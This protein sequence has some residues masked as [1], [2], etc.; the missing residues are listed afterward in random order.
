M[1]AVSVRGLRKSYGDVAALKGVDLAVEEGEIF[2]LL[3]PNGAGKTTTIR[4]LTTLLA[5]DAGE[6]RILGLDPRTKK[7]D[8]RRAIGVALQETGLDDLATGRELIV[9]HGRLHGLARGAATERAGELLSHFG[10]V[11]A[12]DRQVGTYSGGMRRK[13]DLAAALVHRPRLVFLDEPTV[14]LDPS[15]RAQLWGLVRAMNRE[16][17]TTVFLTTHYMEEAERLARRLA[18]VDEGRVVAEGGP[19]DL[20]RG[21]ATQVVTLTVDGTEE[22]VASVEKDLR[23][24]PGVRRVLRLPDALAVHVD[25]SEVRASEARAIAERRGVRVSEVRLAEPTLEDVFLTTTGRALREAE[26]KP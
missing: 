21:V 7:R 13:L 15:A 17:G 11:E 23:A 20:K 25:G 4:I 24:L 6:V 3:G 1:P 5:P 2:G 16:E 14:G 19:A 22:A 18:V 9:L 12:A 8:V 26:A 10:L